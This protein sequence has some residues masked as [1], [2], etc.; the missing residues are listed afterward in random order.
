M[1]RIL[2]ADSLAEEGIAR[3]RAAAG[4]EF[5]LRAG[6]PQG[7]LAAAV[8][9]YDG[10][11]IRSGAKI[12]AEVLANPGRLRAIARA[13]VGVDN[14]DLPAATRAGV[15]VMNTPDGNTLSTA[16]HAFAMLLAL[17]RNIPAACA[18][19]KSGQ[20][21]RAQFEGSQLAGKAL[22]IVGLGRI[23][24]A[25][26]ARALAFD[27]TVIA[28]DPFVSDATALAGRVRIVASLETL[29]A[30]TDYLSVH[31]V[32]TDATRGMIGREQ[33]RHARRG[34][35]IVNCA[36]GGIVDE[37]ALQ[38]ALASGQVAGA[39]L[40]VFAAEPPPKDHPLVAHPR[41]V[42]TPHLG[43]ST[44]EAQ[45]AVAVEAVDALLDY[46]LRDAIRGACNLVGLPA[47]MGPRERAA[48]DL[49]G[50]MAVLLSVFCDA[51]VS[52]VTL[53]TRGESLAG[54]AP[55][56]LRFALV[57]LLSRFSSG[58]INLVNVE[59]FARQRGISVRHV[60]RPETDGPAESLQL[61]AEHAGVSH[62]VAGA[63]QPA[64]PPRLL[65]IDGYPMN[66]V[67]TGTMLLIFNDDRPGVIGFVGT[68]L[69]NLNV[70]IADMALSRHANRAL[71]VLKLD[72]PPPPAAIAALSAGPSILS[73]KSATLPPV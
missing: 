43:A 22:G 55:A 66:L 70:N 27:M 15:L 37:A 35:R 34:L 62:D 11:V 71:M 67:P 52:R 60:A 13:G 10:M 1:V 5:D 45:T 9:G 19:L 29:L 63:V 39:A 69:G 61:S 38:E 3:L 57:S 4:V 41:V 30:E 59:E 28:Y 24:R 25:V 47:A 2:V 20:W 56:L 49:V 36:R 44:A 16:E 50:R 65:A 6:L 73:L 18:D 68:T 7:E 72:G 21:R 42:C 51:G 40:D 54:L 33:L 12:T 48:A 46:L 31:A 32:M 14:V 23:G 53:E 58:R 26:A 8:A 17:A 64:G